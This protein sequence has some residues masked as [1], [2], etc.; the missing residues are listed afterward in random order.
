MTKAMLSRMFM[1][2]KNDAMYLLI[3]IMII[4]MVFVEALNGTLL[5]TKIQV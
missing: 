2:K 5:I 3:I 4:V 1:N